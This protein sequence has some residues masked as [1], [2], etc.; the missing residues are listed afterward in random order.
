MLL[1]LNIL[2]WPPACA[3]LRQKSWVVSEEVTHTNFTISGLTRPGLE[4]TTYHTTQGEDAVQYTV[5]ALA[6]FWCII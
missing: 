3:L 5:E 2:F 4:S 6:Q 1:H